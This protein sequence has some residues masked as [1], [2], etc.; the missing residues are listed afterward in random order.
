M[1]TK[2]CFRKSE[3]K[4]FAPGLDSPNQLEPSRKNGFSAHA[5]FERIF[6]S[7]RRRRSKTEL[8]CPTRLGKNGG[9]FRE[10]RVRFGL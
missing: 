3:I 1:R 2:H 5:I 7:A 10:Q 6:A 8:I 9:Y 4:I